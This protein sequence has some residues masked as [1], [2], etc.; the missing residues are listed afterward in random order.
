MQKKKL[1]WATF[2]PWATHGIPITD[3]LAVKLQ[4]P[5]ES[6]S[7]KNVKVSKSDK[8]EVLPRSRAERPGACIECA[9]QTV[10]G[11]GAGDWS[12]VHIDGWSGA[13]Y[14]EKWY[15]ILCQT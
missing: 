8:N 1:L 9:W 14:E 12:E 4:F 3:E 7:I 11:T 5:H 10:G 13:L 15:T 6:E 2:N